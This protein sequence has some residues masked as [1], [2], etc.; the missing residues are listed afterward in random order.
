MKCVITAIIAVFM[1][2][3]SAISQNQKRLKMES[4]IELSGKTVKHQWIKGPWAGASFTTFFCNNENLIW[5]NTTN[6]NEI[7]SEKEKYIRRDIAEGIVQISWKENP[8]TTDFGL[9]WTLNFNKHKIYGVIVN[10]SKTENINVEGTFEI[11]NSLT[12]EKGLMN[13]H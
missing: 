1:I 8:K 3:T 13:C 5:N 7:S 12:P 2:S 10:A 4:K 6:P 11:I 9:I